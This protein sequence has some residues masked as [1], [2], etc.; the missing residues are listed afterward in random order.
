MPVPTVRAG[1]SAA[2]Q[3]LFE[4]AGVIATGSFGELTETAALLATQPV[5]AG[6]TVAI[7]ANAGGAGVLAAD[8]CAEL[9]LTV[10]QP[11]GLTRRR[12]RTLLP[13]GTVTGPVDTTAAVSAGDFRRCL[14][15]LAADDGVDAMIALVL[16]TGATGDLIPAIQAADVGVPLAAVELGQAESVR[17]MSRPAGGQIPVFD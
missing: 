14:E 1:H 12:L 5:P 16:P 7:V 10:H 2:D 3:A 11:R 9:G 8:A 6:R 4:Q 13:G 15:V 17:L